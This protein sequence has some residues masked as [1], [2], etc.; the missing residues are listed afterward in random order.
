MQNVLDCAA[1]SVGPVTFVRDDECHYDMNALP[2]GQR[3]SI[4]KETD[5]FM[6]GS[7]GLPINVQV[8]GRPFDDELVLRVMKEIEAELIRKQ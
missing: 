1:G 2:K 6:R 3:D 7:Q 4:S 5:G 8:F